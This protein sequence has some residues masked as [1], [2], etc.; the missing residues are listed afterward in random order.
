[1]KLAITREQLN[2]CERWI[3]I[4]RSGGPGGKVE[5]IEGSNICPWIIALAWIWGSE[6]GCALN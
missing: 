6:K 1:M 4:D 3:G 5:E 2:Q